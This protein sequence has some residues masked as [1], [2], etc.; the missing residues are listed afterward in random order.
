MLK[1]E[2]GNPLIKLGESLI[3]FDTWN[4]L[5]KLVESMTKRGQSEIKLDESKIKLGKP[6]I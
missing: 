2:L 3:N 5:I 6:M 1:F 4:V